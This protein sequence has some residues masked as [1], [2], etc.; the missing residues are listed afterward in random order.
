M[1]SLIL[2]VF[3]E[4]CH[5]FGLTTMQLFEYCLAGPIDRAES[6]AVATI[7]WP[8]SYICEQDM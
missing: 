2:P 4:T 5:T 8:K 1:A 6:A 3:V 7:L